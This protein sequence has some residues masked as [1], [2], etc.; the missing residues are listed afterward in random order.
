MKYF[1]LLNP[2]KA[3]QL[4]K[5]KYSKN[6]NNEEAENISYSNFVI[7]FQRLLEMVQNCDQCRLTGV[8]DRDRAQLL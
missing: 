7:N 8:M 3:F 1:E 6:Y 5:H 2:E 4:F